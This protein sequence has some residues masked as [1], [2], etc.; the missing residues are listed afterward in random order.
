M[1]QFESDLQLACIQAIEQVTGGA[2]RS[3]AWAWGFAA[4]VPSK[5]K[6]VAPKDDPLSV[7]CCDCLLRRPL[8]PPGGEG[9]AEAAEERP[10]Q[11]VGGFGDGVGGNGHVV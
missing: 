10:D 1:R 3:N 8:P 11:E 9:D 7:R 5:C 6:R 2:P 4:S